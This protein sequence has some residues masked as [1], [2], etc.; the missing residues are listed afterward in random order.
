MLA[1]KVAVTAILWTVATALGV[2][3]SLEPDEVTRFW[4]LM[5]AMV[6]SLLTAH[7]IACQAVRAERLRIESVVEG[8]VA[9]ARRRA[10]ADLPRVR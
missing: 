5:V 2:A 4:S 3:G 9:E 6:A 10:E 1:A 8:M 7:L